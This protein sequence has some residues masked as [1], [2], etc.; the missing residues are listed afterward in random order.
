MHPSDT[1]VNYNS[2]N[3]PAYPPWGQIGKWVR[4]PRMWWNTSLWKCYIYKNYA[5]R[6][7]FPKTYNPTANDGKK[8]PMMLFFHGY[9]EIGP[10]TDNEFHMLLGHQFF[11]NQVESQNFDGYVLSMQSTGFFGANH[12]QALAEIIQYMVVNNKLDP[13]HVVTNGLSAGGQ[14][15]WDMMI[16]HPSYVCAALPMSWTSILYTDAAVVEKIKFAPIWHFQGGLDGNPAP[17]TTNY[18]QGV[19]NGAGGRMQN[20]LYPDKDHE[21]WHNAWAEPDFIP[22]IKRAYASNPWPLFGKTEYYQGEPI[23]ATL[24]LNPGY[25]AYEWRKRGVPIPGGS[26]TL[27]VTDTG[28]YE[29]RVMMHGLWSEWSRIPVHIKLKPSPTMPHKIEAEN[30]I[31][32][33]GVQT[34]PT[35]DAGGGL[36]VGYV[37]NGDWMEYGVVPPVNGTYALKLRLASPNTGGQLQIRKTDGT[38]LA[39]VNVPNTGGWQVWQTVTATFSLPANYNGLRLVSTASAGWNINWLELSQVTS[40]PVANAG[41]D[42]IIHLP[43]NSTQ[44]NGSGTDP[45]GTITAFSWS[46]I[47]GPTTFSI[48]NANVANPTLSNLV[49]GVYTFRLT[50]T[51]N[52]GN[53]GTDDVVVTVNQRPTSNA[54][55]DQTIHLPTNS[56]QLNGATSTDADGTITTYAWSKV[57]G[58]AGSTFSSTSVVNPTVNNLAAGVHTFRLTVTDN[59]GGTATDDVVITVNQ[60]PVVNAGGD[61]TLSLPTNATPLTGS[62]SDPD[63]GGSIATYSWTKQSGPDQYTLSST[64][65]ANPTLSNLVVGVYTFT[66]TATDNSGGSASDDVVITVNPQQGVPTANAGADQI[67]HLPSNSIQLNGSGTDTDGTITSYSWSKLSGPTYTISDSTVAN[68]TISNLVAGVYTFRLTVTDNDGKIAT[69][70]VVITV[71]TLPVANAGSDQTIH[72]PTNTANLSGSATDADAAS[73]ISYNW[74]RVSGPTTF[75]ISNATIANPTLSNLVAGTY[76]FRLTATDNNGGSNTDD[77]VII[78]NTPPVA[79]AGADVTLTLPT[80]ATQLNGSG[81]DADAGGS[82][83]SYSWSRVSGPTTFTISNANVANPTLSNLVQGTY[84]FRLTVTDNR[85]GTGTDDVVINVVPSVVRIQAENYSAMLGVQT[86][87]TTDAGGGLNVGYINVNDWMDYTINVATAGTHTLWLRVATPYTG[88][89]LQVKNSGGTVLATVNLPQTGGWQTWATA[90]SQLNLPAGTQTIRIQSTST[91][92]WNFNWME[93]MYGVPASGKIEAEMYT[94]MQGIQT[95]VTADVGGGLNVGYVDLNDWMEYSV[96]TNAAGNY[97]INFRLAARLSTGQL[98]IR[99][100]DGTVLATLTTPLTGGWQTWQTVTAT[101]VPL[102]AG[103]QTIRIVS[104]ASGNWNFNWFEIVQPS[105]GTSTRMDVMPMNSSRPDAVVTDPTGDVAETYPNPVY[106]Q[107]VLR[108]NNEYSGNLSVQVFTSNGALQ[109]QVQLNKQK[110]LSQHTISLGSLPKGEY[111]LMIDM[112]GRRITKKIT[113]L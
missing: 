78:V 17:Y 48:S 53:T 69:D 67:L 20:T 44:L 73:T 112:K 108:L 80:N 16:N 100:T 9:G 28:L 96:T 71:N 46:P 107:M 10:N 61:V 32:M 81:T 109:K 43:T 76:T 88:Q 58:P 51:D 49:N 29:A 42:Q 91:A 77:V 63:A 3:P 18:V 31:S 37:D 23:N 75:T 33:S 103:T 86:E 59:N 24:G 90:V 25:A 6:L 19:I 4:T 111:I 36:N 85:G 82:V 5:F 64:S 15:T 40:A 95:E 104:T 113:K 52:G 93:L 105:G 101:N 57:S 47:S 12:Y 92:G 34:E 83:S 13:F 38:T 45:D 65:I 30:W 74:S 21:T 102:A 27:V 97:N 50:V 7:K 110:G 99:R 79:N 26:N 70:D 1:I 84:T 35:S 98:Q 106:D 22:Y 41:T 11:E 14:A 55:A 68:P 8:Y 89:T 94:A 2:A 72:L 60:L 62:A 39:T 54:G 87:T 56:V 66:L